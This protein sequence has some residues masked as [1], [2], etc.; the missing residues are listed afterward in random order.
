M[1]TEVTV[2]IAGEAGQGIQTIGTL[3]AN[4]CHNAGLFVFSVND[5][6]SRIRGGYSFNILRIS[7]DPLIAPSGK[8]DILVAIDEKS[9]DRDMDTHADGGIVLLNTKEQKDL[10]DHVHAVSFDELASSAGGRIASNTVAAGMLLSIL[11]SGFDRLEKELTDQF[12][13]KGEK[14]LD[15]NK[16][17]AF[18]GFE[19]GEAVPFSE[20]L[21][22]ESS[23]NG[24]VLMSGAYAAALGALASNC[25]VFSFYPMSPATGIMAS[26]AEFTG[27]LPIVVEQAEDEL[28]AVNMAIGSSFA[29]VRSLTSTSGGGFSLMTEGLGLAAMTETP[30]VIINGQRPGP[31]TGLPTRTAQADLLFTIT[32]SQDEFPRFV[33]A[34]GTVLETFSAVKKAFHLSDKY[35]VP[36]IVLLDQFLCDSVMTEKGTLEMDS[37]GDEKNL[38]CRDSKPG[39]EQSGETGQPYLRYRFSENGISDRRIPGTSKALV[40][41]TANEHDQEGNITEDAEIRTKMV[42]KRHSKIEYMKEEMDP[43]SIFSKESA[44]LLAGWGSS[45]GSIMESCL[46][47]RSLGYDVGWL[48][49]HDIW[50][51]DWDQVSEVVTDRKLILV[52]QNRT[53]QLGRLIRQQTGIAFSDSVRKYDG[54]PLYPDFI[55]ENV[56]KMME[57]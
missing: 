8:P 53:C 37:R 25:R 56:K 29:G 1:A 44:V 11:G 3:L 54:R 18:A 34:P 46:T 23:G 36:A 7:E 55:T 16:K 49:F 31:A 14:V 9:A 2:K 26:A 50:P 27:R 33:L 17:A 38:E 35:Q 40:R 12:S 24:N 4:V 45:R 15:L 6:E 51:L 52:E 41:S 22:F 28:A 43:P 13:R 42:D 57:Q 39:K 30:L 5:F 47:L 19:K 21:K 10:P 32:A 20:K 48:I